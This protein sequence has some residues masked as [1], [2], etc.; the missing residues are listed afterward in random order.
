MAIGSLRGIFTT[1]VF[2]PQ[3]MTAS[4]LEGFGRVKRCIEMISPPSVE[5]GPVRGGG[6]AAAGLFGRRDRESLAYLIHAILRIVEGHEGVHGTQKMKPWAKLTQSAQSV[7]T[8]PPLTPLPNYV[9]LFVIVGCLLD[10]YLILPWLLLK[11]LHPRHIRP[12]NLGS[13]DKVFG[14]SI[15]P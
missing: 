13:A 6:I 15:S 10:T 12:V 7:D 11:T 9:H 1:E 14:P 5:S 4:G 3:P 8:S 2:P